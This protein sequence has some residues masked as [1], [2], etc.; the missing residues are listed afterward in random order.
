MSG[1]PGRIDVTV[2]FVFGVIAGVSMCILLLWATGSIGPRSWC[3]G[4][5]ALSVDHQQ[6]VQYM[7]EVSESQVAYLKRELFKSMQEAATHRANSDTCQN[8]LSAQ[9]P[10]AAMC[11][12]IHEV[13]KVDLA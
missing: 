11:A 1:R 4:N 3:S 13:G 9:C 6:L 12:S 2:V 10:M 5:Q 8:A 7:Q